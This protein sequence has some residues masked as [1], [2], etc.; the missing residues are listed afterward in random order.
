MVYLKKILVTTDLSPFS[1]AAIDYASSFGL[2]YSSELTLLH[3]VESKGEHR[4]GAEEAQKSLDEFVRVNLPASL[5]I[6]PIVRF[7]HPAEEIR[8]FA[9][10]ENVDLI[11][12]ATHGR[13]GLRHMVMGS[14]A[15][16]V[17]RVSPI[18][19]LAVKPHPVREFLIGT[20]DVEKDLHLR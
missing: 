12:M 1:L 6:V 5:D 11:V 19:V 13:T 10:Q 14:V 3:V 15:E 7:G 17:V 8:R 16:R 2:L 20:D 4:K 9:E 18:P